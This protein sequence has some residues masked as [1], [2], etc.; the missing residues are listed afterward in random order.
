MV[1]SDP[2]RPFCR[3]SAA[4]TGTVS[5]LAFQ[6]EKEALDKLG[7]VRGFAPY[8]RRSGRRA[9]GLPD[10]NRWRRK[11]YCTHS[12]RLPACIGAAF[13]APRRLRG[14]LSLGVARRKRRPAGIS[15]RPSLLKTEH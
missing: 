9:R 14:K 6:F 2:D 5:N 12:S 13:F 4:I 11:T 3:L 10:R 7:G 1:F 8:R 15:L